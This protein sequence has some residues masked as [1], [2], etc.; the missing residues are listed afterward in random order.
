MRE[1]SLLDIMVQCLLLG[2]ASCSS[3]ASFALPALSK[4]VGEERLPRILQ[5]AEVAG[6]EET[7]EP[8]PSAGEGQLAEVAEADGGEDAEVT[9]SARGAEE[10]LTEAG[11]QLTEAG[12]GGEG[13]ELAPSASES[14][15]EL[16]EAGGGGELTELVPCAGSL[17][18][19]VS[20]FQVLEARPRDIWPNISCCLKH[21]KLYESKYSIFSEFEA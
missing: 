13:S 6:G 20:L 5:V 7:S 21:I 15:G 18:K 14:E 11:G 2:S 19:L 4:L 1:A 12:G 17:L 9:P 10:Q 16:A 3:S 8:A